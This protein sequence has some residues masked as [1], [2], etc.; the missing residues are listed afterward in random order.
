M[1]RGDWIKPGATVIDVGIN[2]IPRD[3]GKFRIVGDVAYVEAAK[4]AGA[5]TPVPG[6]VGPMTIACLLLNTLRAACAQ[7][8]L[9]APKV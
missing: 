9:P 5:I 1:I 8:G 6:G 2:R 4:I 7:N 3:G